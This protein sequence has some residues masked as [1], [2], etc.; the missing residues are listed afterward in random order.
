MEDTPSCTNSPLVPSRAE[1]ATASCSANAASSGPVTSSEQIPYEAGATDSGAEVLLYIYAAFKGGWR[2]ERPCLPASACVARP[3]LLIS[4]ALS[5]VCPLLVF[6]PA[7]PHA[8]RQA[9]VV[10]PP[11]PWRIACLSA[12]SPVLL[13]LPLL[14]SS[15]LLPHRPPSLPF[16]LSSPPLCTPLSSGF[17]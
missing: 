10:P 7:K 15:P 9:L 6:P 4:Q 2:G 12:P 5:C 13:A 17:D 16:A 11:N 1:T 3:R 8:L 14:Y